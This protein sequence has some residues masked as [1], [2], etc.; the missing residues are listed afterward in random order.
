MKKKKRIKGAETE[1]RIGEGIP[2]SLKIFKM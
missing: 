1:E 2:A